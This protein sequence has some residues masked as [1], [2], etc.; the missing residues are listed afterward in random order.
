[1]EM[2]EIT[3]SR[4]DKMSLMDVESTMLSDADEAEENKDPKT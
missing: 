2:V 3:L 4:E 1:M